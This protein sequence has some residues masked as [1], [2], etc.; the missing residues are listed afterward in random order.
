MTS[1]CPRCG[2]QKKV[3]ITVTTNMATGKMAETINCM[4]CGYHT[5]TDITPETQN[6]ARSE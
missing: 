4:N 1:Q 3:A 2:E 6:A 5:V